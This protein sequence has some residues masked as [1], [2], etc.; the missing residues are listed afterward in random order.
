MAEPDFEHEK[1][2]QEE[3]N[4]NRENAD[5]H[6]EVAFIERVKCRRQN[7]HRRISGQSDRIKLQGAGRLPRC[8]GS[9]SAVLINHTDDRLRKDDQSDRS[10]NCQQRDQSNR[11]RQSRTKGGHVAERGRAGD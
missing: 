10:R 3:I 7:F 11:V 6:R 9:E 2:V 1:P 8:F 4:R 5:H